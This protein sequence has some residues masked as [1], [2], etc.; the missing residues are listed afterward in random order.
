MDFIKIIEKELGKKANI[1]FMSMQP[2]D[3]PETFADIEDTSRLTGFQP[4]TTIAEGVPRF[5]AWYKDY[6]RV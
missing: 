3:V 6:Y 1:E 4:T 2:G 5:I